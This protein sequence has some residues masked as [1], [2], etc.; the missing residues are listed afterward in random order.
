MACAVEGVGLPVVRGALG[1]GTW[2]WRAMGECCALGRGAAR[3]DAGPKMTS[4]IED[5]S[6]VVEACVCAASGSLGAL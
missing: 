6:V 1:L 3:C 2:D 4:T 5:S